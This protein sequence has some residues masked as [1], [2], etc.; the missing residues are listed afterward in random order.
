M[1]SHHRFYTALAGFKNL[2]KILSFL[3]QHKALFVG[4]SPDLFLRE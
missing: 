2:Y 1:E 3:Q 4:A